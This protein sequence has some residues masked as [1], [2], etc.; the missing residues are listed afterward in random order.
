MSQVAVEELLVFIQEDMTQS[1]DEPFP[2][3]LPD[4]KDPEGF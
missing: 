3:L 1:V 2:I 4:L